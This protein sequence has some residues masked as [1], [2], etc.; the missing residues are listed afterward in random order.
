MIIL[1]YFCCRDAIQKVLPTTTLH[2]SSQTWFLLSHFW[3]LESLIFEISHVQVHQDLGQSPMPLLLAAPCCVIA[4]RMLNCG[5]VK[6]VKAA[7]T[8]ERNRS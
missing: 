3:L 5:S 6:A 1:T 2:S 4:L 7:Q 8:A